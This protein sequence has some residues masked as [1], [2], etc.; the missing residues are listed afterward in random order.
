MFWQFRGVHNTENGLEDLQEIT[1]V[2]W[3]ARKASENALFSSAISVIST[4]MS[5]LPLPPALMILKWYKPPRD[6]LTLALWMATQTN[7][8]LQFTL[9]FASYLISFRIYREYLAGAPQEVGTVLMPYATVGNYFV[10][11]LGGIFVVE[12]P[13][14][15]W[16]FVR[17]VQ[18]WTTT[19]RNR[20]SIWLK[21]LA[22][23]FGLTGIVLFLQIIGGYSVFFFFL[24]LASP[25]TAVSSLAAQ[26]NVTV[27]FLLITAFL[28]HPCVALKTGRKCFRGCGLLLFFSLG[29]LGVLG[30]TGMLAAV[31]NDNLTAPLN[32]SQIATSVM[33]SSLLALM[34]Y[35]AKKTLLRRLLQSYSSEREDE[36]LPLLDPP[37]SAE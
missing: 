13:F 1:D 26:A 19:S 32:A 36:E 31:A 3:P 4:L 22:H 18:Q 11:A 9:F 27:F 2:L 35:T 15:M 34:A 8:W 17:K 33:S 6:K 29:S 7:S 30:Y 20:C 14:V 28:I 23:S 5:L 37:D 12:L 25:I 16:Y 21:I 10:I 24:L